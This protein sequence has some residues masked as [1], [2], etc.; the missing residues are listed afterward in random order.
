MNFYQLTILH[1]DSLHI[2]TIQRFAH[3]YGAVY[4]APTN[5]KDGITFEF[6]FPTYNQ[7]KDFIAALDTLN[8]RLFSK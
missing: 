7:M 1:K 5:N 8:P 4:S 6:E 3:T 2:S